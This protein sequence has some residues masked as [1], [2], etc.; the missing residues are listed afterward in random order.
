MTRCLAASHTG[1]LNTYCGNVGAIHV[2]HVCGRDGGVVSV[3]MIVECSIMCIIIEKKCSDCSNVM[4][5]GITEQE[6][7]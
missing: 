2:S 3:C 1:N 6:C 5:C 4:V 7:V